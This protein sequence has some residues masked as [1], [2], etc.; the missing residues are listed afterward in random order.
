MSKDKL[1]I[2]LPNL[3]KLAA[4][5]RINTENILICIETQRI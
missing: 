5:A 3:A 2:S 1:L 4:K